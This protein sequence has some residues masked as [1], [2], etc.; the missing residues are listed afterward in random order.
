[1]SY[2]TLEVTSDDRSCPTRLTIPFRSR[3][4]VNMPNLSEKN[5]DRDEVTYCHM[6]L[7]SCLMK[8]KS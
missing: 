1:M 7:D 2:L 3:G 4:A 8:Q 6:I 5:L